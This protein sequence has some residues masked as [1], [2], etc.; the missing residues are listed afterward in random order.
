[1]K[2]IIVF[3]GFL[4]ICT[5]PVHGAPVDLV[6]LDDSGSEMSTGFWNWKGFYSPLVTPLP[7][8]S[9]HCFPESEQP[10][11]NRVKELL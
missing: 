6:R 11:G 9:R 1:M 2:A 3:I 10:K 8:Y 4:A 7:F 5:R